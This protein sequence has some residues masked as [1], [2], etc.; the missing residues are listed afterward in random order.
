MTANADVMTSSDTTSP[1]T[2]R[3]KTSTSSTRLATVVADRA[4][5]SIENSFGW[6]RMRKTWNGRKK[7]PPMK[8]LTIIS[9]S[10]S[11]WP[12]TLKYH[13]EYHGA[14][15]SATRRMKPLAASRKNRIVLASR[16]RAASSSQS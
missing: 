14:V 5:V 6:L 9:C 16:C 11:V 4:N 8:V 12:G 3:W 10:G 2:P 13:S 1:I 7:K 15:T